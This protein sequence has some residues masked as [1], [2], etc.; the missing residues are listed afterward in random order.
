MLP[1]D[2]KISRAERL[3]RMIEEDAPLLARRVAELTPERQ[4]QASGYVAE[5]A[6]QTR[7]EIARLLEELHRSDPD[8]TVPEPAD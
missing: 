2:A 6:A 7:A 4:K 5:L 8:E 1:I 3:L